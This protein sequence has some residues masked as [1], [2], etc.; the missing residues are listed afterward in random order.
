[1]EGGIEGAPACLLDL[2]LPEHPQTATSPSFPR[3]ENRRI[4]RQNTYAQHTNFAL[5]LFSRSVL[6]VLDRC[7]AISE[8]SLSFS[9]QL[10]QKIPPSCRRR[11]VSTFLFFFELYRAL[12]AV[13]AFSRTF[14]LVRPCAVAGLG[15]A[16]ASHTKTA[17]A[18]TPPPTEIHHKRTPCYP[19]QIALP[20]GTRRGSTSS[21]RLEDDSSCTFAMDL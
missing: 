2:D 21:A 14:L 17:H 18:A 9:S 12:R 19:E 3:P 11:S 10:P 16:F 1:M 13:P 8:I 15:A 7:I 6:R 4:C 20:Q 5:H